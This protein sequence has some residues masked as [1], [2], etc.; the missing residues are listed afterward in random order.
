[1]YTL[2]FFAQPRRADVFTEDEKKLLKTPIIRPL[3]LDLLVDTKV[4]MNL[5]EAYFYCLL[6]LEAVY[7]EQM[8]SPYA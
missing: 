8:R 2:G 4:C 3:F 6:K 5:A 7:N 1:M